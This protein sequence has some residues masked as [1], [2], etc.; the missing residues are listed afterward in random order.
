MCNLYDKS[1]YIS[2]FWCGY[3]RCSPENWSVGKGHM[4][5][6][7]GGTVAIS[8]LCDG[9]YRPRTFDVFFDVNNSIPDWE[10]CGFLY[11]SNGFVGECSPSVL[12]F[13]FVILLFL[14]KG[15]KMNFSHFLKDSPREVCLERQNVRQ[16]LIDISFLRELKSKFP[17]TV[18]SHST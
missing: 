8:A 13:W 6:N 4:G 16:T 12:L 14:T 15:K 1:V 5:S 2:S 9:V 11:I 17:G 18:L 3:C 7:V 10:K